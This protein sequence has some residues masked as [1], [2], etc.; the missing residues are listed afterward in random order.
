MNEHRHIPSYELFILALSLYALAALAI[1]AIVPLDV[2]TRQIMD[3]T[4]YGVC[5]VFFSDFVLHFFR[6]E[7]PGRY[8]I[9]WGWIDLASSVPAV[10][11]LRLGRVARVFRIVRV[12]RGVKATKLIASFILERR[13]QGAFLAV[14]LL[15][16]LLTMSAAIAILHLENT[17]DANIKG[18]GDAI[19]WAVVTITT[20][21]YGDRYPV[22][23]E[24]RVLGALLMV[25]GVGLFATLSGFVASW[26][27]K[28]THLQQESDIDKLRVEITSL[29]LALESRFKE[30]GS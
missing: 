20:V 4:D 11:I 21:G 12:L 17:P 5:F 27:L 16:V 14:S 1:E 22:T 13:A 9:T 18:A 19:W 3:W 7:K 30:L 8:F 2:A 26:F 29:R 10:S 23:P 28:P 25:A 6:A 15:S 24:G